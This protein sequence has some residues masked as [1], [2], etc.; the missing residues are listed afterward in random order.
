VAAQEGN[1]EEDTECHGIR[2][3]KLRSV[4]IIR[5]KKT[6][7]DADRKNGSERAES[8]Q[9]NLKSKTVEEEFFAHGAT[10]QEHREEKDRAPVRAR[11]LTGWNHARH[12][13]HQRHA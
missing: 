13:G 3:T 1:T 5:V 11:V 7:D 4:W 12:T 6:E 2:D 9:Q 8:F 10:H